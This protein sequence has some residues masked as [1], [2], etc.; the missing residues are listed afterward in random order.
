MLDCFIER[1]D[2]YFNQNKLIPIIPVIHEDWKVKLDGMKIRSNIKSEIITLAGSDYRMQEAIVQGKEFRK[3][4]TFELLDMLGIK[5]SRNE[6]DKYKALINV[7]KSIR[8]LLDIVP[9]TR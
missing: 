5:R 9:E 1:Q 7:L 4:V 2:S 3:E 6:K 8:I